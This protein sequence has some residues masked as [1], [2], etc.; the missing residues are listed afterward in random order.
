MRAWNLMRLAAG[1]SSRNQGEKIVLPLPPGLGDAHP[2]GVNRF[3]RGGVQNAPSAYL[4]AIA[5]GVIRPI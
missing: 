3:S 4:P 1:G 5:C 2:D